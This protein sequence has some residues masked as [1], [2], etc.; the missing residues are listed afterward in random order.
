MFLFI[1]HS[2]TTLMR[3]RTQRSLMKFFWLQML[4]WQK[5][6]SC[7]LKLNKGVTDGHILI[8]QIYKYKTGVPGHRP[9]QNQGEKKRII[10]A[11]VLKL[12]I[13]AYV[14]LDRS[15]GTFAVLQ[16]SCQVYIWT[17]CIK[18]DSNSISNGQD[19]L[20]AYQYLVQSQK[21]FYPN[22]INFILLFICTLQKN[23]SV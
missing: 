18:T 2:V 15:T 16:I 3:Q 10:I 4:L 8:E 23:L 13:V 5:I 9:Q 11:A 17:N 7:I 19:D 6:K 14:N 20:R 21:P 12:Y 22:T 1:L